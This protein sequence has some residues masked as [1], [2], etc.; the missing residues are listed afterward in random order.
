MSDVGDK[1][2][3]AGIVQAQDVGQVLIE[4]DLFS[5]DI[6]TG[7]QNYISA[8][9]PSIQSFEQM[10]GA[11]SLDEEGKEAYAVIRILD[12]EAVIEDVKIE[13]VSIKDIVSKRQADK[14]ESSL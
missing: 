13:D 7:S 10:I 2:N 4:G 8:V 14:S 6:I 3:V 11:S 9:M 12:G 5:K 1:A